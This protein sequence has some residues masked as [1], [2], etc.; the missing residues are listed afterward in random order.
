MGQKNH[1]VNCLAKRIRRAH[2]NKEEFKVIV[3]MPLLPGFDGDVENPKCIP[4]RAQVNNQY[5][6]INRGE[7]SLFK[8]L[9]GL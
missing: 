7:K 6:A 3:M 8:Q 9:V 1:I 4:L 2:L 5:E